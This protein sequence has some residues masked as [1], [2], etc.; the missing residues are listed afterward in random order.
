MLASSALKAMRSW[1]NRRARRNGF[2]ERAWNDAPVMRFVTGRIV[3]ASYLLC[4]VS[5]AA[6]VTPRYDAVIVT[7]VFLFTAVVEIVNVAE[8]EPAG[9]V[10]LA[11]RLACIGL[12]LASITTAPLSGAGPLRVTVPTELAPSE[13]V[14][15]LSVNDANSPGCTDKLAV[16]VIPE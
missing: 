15:G 14:E 12:V 8:R 16:F 9:T 7:T 1:R 5:V 4:N 10:T 6:F 13:T 3:F 2:G 11:G